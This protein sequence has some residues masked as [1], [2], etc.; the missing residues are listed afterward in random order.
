[1]RT[2]AVLAV[3]TTLAVAGCG[4][5]ADKNQYVNSVNQATTTLTRE[6]SAIGNVGGGDPAAIAT[7]L[8]KGGKAIDKAADDFDTIPPPDDAKHAHG[9]MVSGLHALAGTFRQAADA[10]R[11]K[12][13]TKLIAIVGDIQ[14]SAG[15]KELEAAQHELEANG[16]KFQS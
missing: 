2:F 6:M 14:T 13:T 3:L 8:E 16:Y 12:D 11:A 7:T 1:M 10:A 9:Q 4:S 5:T 15:A